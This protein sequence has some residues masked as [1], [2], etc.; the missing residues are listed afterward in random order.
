MASDQEWIKENKHYLLPFLFFFSRIILFLTLVPYGYY[1]IGDLD[2]YREWTALPGWPYLDYWVEYPPLFPFL[3][4]ILFRVVGEQSF[5]Y[6]FLMALVL[7]FAGAVT[8]FLFQKIASRL[9]DDRVSQIRSLILFGILVVLPY[10]WWYADLITLALMMAGIWSILEKKDKFAGLWI[11]LGMLAKWFPVFLLPAL[12]RQRSLKNIFQLTSIALVVVLIVFAILYVVSPEMTT[13]SLMAQPARSSWQTI[14][15]LMDRNLTTGAYLTT[16]QRLDPVQSTIPTRNPPV[17]PPLLTL[18]IFCGIGIILL[19]QQ[20]QTSD[21]NY[22][23]NIGVVWILFL[24]WS[25]GWSSQWVLYILPLLLLTLPLSTGV[26]LS[27]LLVTINLIEFPFLLGRNVP[28]SL[29]VLVPIRTLMLIIMLILWLMMP[30]Y[31]P[32]QFQHTR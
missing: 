31:I 20:S 26:L 3:S 27:L 15:A 16:E 12:I 25:P 8:L 32:E 24:L 11:G 6:D 21:F 29:W 18:P 9:Y 4:E 23:M 14:W 5:L 10:T 1:G 2:V 13:A 19:A 7:A 28:A 30:K 17:V 22:L